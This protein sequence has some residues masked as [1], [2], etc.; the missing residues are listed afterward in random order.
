MSTVDVDVDDPV[1]SQL[2][3]DMH[4]PRQQIAV[5]CLGIKASGKST[6]AMALIRYTLEN[7]LYNEWFLFPPAFGKDIEHSYDF[8]APFADRVTIFTYYNPAF[9]EYLLQREPEELEKLDKGT[10]IF[11]DDLGCNADFNASDKHFFRLVGVQRHLKVSTV[12]NFHSLAPQRVISPFLR[13]NQTCYLC[14]KITNWK[15]IEGWWREVCSMSKQCPDFKEFLKRFREN[16]HADFDKKKQEMI[17]N[18]NGVA[19]HCTSGQMLWTL[20]NWFEE[21]RL[22]NQHDNEKQSTSKSQQS[23]KKELEKGQREWQLTRSVGEG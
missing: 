5:L 21:E 17:P 12:V 13:A 4:N 11:L 6:R 2:I 3:A 23:T 9:A 22:K 1:L 8:L 18:F 20:K 16:T 7:N 19:I 14:T 10:L 15:I